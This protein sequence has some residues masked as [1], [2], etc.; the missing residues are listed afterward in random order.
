MIFKKYLILIIS[1][2][3]AAI[4]FNVILNPNNLVTGGTQGLAIIITKITKYSPSTII[5]IINLI[6]LFVSFIFLSK[7][8]TC[9]I[10]AS[11]LI[12]P[13]WIKLTTNIQPLIL[14]RI[15]LS[16]I[17]GTICGITNGLIFKQNFSSGGITV[18]NIL[19]KKYL[20]IKL[21]ISN[22][23]INSIIIIIG[24]TLFG[25]L[26]VIYSLIVIT[27]SS[28]IIYFIMNKKTSLTKTK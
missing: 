20:N 21:S 24:S 19:L 28:L 1:L 8:T 11:S 27:I 18:L 9:S 23:I 2:L 4:N 3:L 14:P 17:A 26:K 15:I 5:L 13:F 10:I 22:F 16:I 12:Y 6:A 7:K 25:F